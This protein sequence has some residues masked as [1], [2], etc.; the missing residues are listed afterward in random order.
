LEKI[1]TRIRKIYI[2]RIEIMHF[3]FFGDSFTAGEEL[4]DYKFYNNYPSPVSFFELQQDVNKGWKQKNKSVREILS[5]ER[6][7]K[8]QCEQKLHSYAHKLSNKMGIPYDNLAVGG[9]G[10][11]RCHHELINYVNRFPERKLTVFIQPPSYKRWLEFVDNKWKNYIITYEPQSLLEKDY[12][13][14]KI[15][16]NTEHSRFIEWY[17]TLQSIYD[18]CQNAENIQE[19]FFINYGIFNEITGKKEN[20]NFVKG[21]EKLY[22]KIKTKLF[23][24]PHTLDLHKPNFLPYGHVVEENHEQL[25]IAIK[26]ELY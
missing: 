22:K 17:I 13:K 11:S 6:F 19:I 7:E 20:D 5:K 8:L 1:I 15:I 10:L 4:L 12:F 21:Y 26:E 23:H 2:R 14:F 24:F 16:N 18:F 9:I 3:V 25:A